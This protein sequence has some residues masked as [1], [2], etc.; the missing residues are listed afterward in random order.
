MSLTTSELWPYLVLVLAGFLPNEIWRW[1]GFMLARGVDQESEILVWVRAV[2]TAVLAAVI[3]KLIFFAPG[4][5]ASV[6]LAV[7]LVAIAAG[8][9]GFVL[10]RRSVFAG[11]ATGEAVLILGA[12]AL[13]P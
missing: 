7:R 10:F 2:A 8:F 12:L 3:A 5:L 13:R 4:A 6:P 1:L 11:V 9:V